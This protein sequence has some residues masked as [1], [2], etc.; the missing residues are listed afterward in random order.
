MR[1]A[2][3]AVIALLLSGCLTAELSPQFYRDRQQQA[4]DH[5]GIEVLSVQIESLGPEQTAVDATVRVT[6]IYRCSSARALGDVLHIR[7]IH[8][9]P[10]RVVMGPRPIPLLEAGE[11]CPAWLQPDPDR[12]GHEPAARG[13]SFQAIR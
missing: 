13:Y 9:H 12:Q 11:T 7:Y 3:L 6:T 4:P 1:H 10:K 8:D 5:Y 2:L